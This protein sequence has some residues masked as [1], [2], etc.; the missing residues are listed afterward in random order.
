MNL[1][2]RAQL[3]GGFA[4]AIALLIAVFGVSFWGMNSMA[5]A[6]DEI[7][8]E[9]VPA[10]IAVRQ[11]EAL[12]LEQTITYA[13]YA[14]TLDPNDLT[15]VAHEIEEVE[16]AVVSLHELFGHDPEADRLIDVFEAEYAIFIHE[17]ARFI[18]AVQSA[19]GG[20]DSAPALHGAPE[21]PHSAKAENH[22]GGHGSAPGDDHGS[23]DSHG[24]TTNSEIVDLLHV[25]EAE[26][27]KMIAELEELAHFAE[28]KVEHAAEAASKAE[29][30]AILFSSII[31]VIA[32]V[33][34]AF[35]AYT[36]TRKI[37]NGLAQ[38]EAVATDMSEHTLPT[39]VRNM[40]L[41]A[42]GDLTTTF[43]TDLA[44][45][46][47]GQDDEIGKIKR[48]FNR[49]QGA[50]RNTGDSY[51]MM[52]REVSGLVGKV[53]E[54]SIDMTG[55]SGQLADASSQAGDATQ[56]LADASQQV[57]SGA[58]EQATNIQKSSQLVDELITS[59]GQVAEGSEKQTTEV[60][61]AQGVVSQVANASKQ[62][63]ENAQGATEGAQSA[64]KA[65]ENGVEVVQQ[66]IQGMNSIND[67]VQNVATEVANLGERSQEIGKIV[68]VIDDIAAQTNLLALNA[69]IE[70]A[71]AGEQGRGFA[72][73]ADEVRQLAERVSQATS[74]IAGLIESVQESVSTSVQATETGTK[75]V[76]EGT[77]LASGAGEALDEIIKAV[78]S[79][80]Q[81]VEEISGLAEEVSASSNEMVDAIDG[82]S[83]VAT[84]NSA[85]AAKMN[86][87]S[88]EVKGS[89]E[90]VS[91]VT[92]E[93]SAAAEETSASTE[94]MS[95]QVEEVVASAQ[96]LAEMAESLERSVEVFKISSDQQTRSADRAPTAE[97]AEPAGVEDEDA[98]ESQEAAA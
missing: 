96:T 46:D 16:A 32:A 58:Q 98:E 30:Q 51:N 25:L 42:S 50:V 55:A 93:T 61:R 91:A 33:A 38:V 63:A 26:E 13:D 1:T 19:A 69:A 56:G 78:G 35:L 14:I 83:S 86:D 54:M 3:I 80:T 11:L 6:T 60:N 34:L 85:V 52:M 43:D 4:L 18:E 94:E 39:L 74:E 36:L 40:E 90:A 27:E 66:T 72:V 10:D 70:A 65:A 64:N 71:R 77:T 75:Q 48:A 8:H 88:S 59:V 7:V 23:G 92:E 57:A 24:T 84:E 21:E 97:V 41:A 12:V 67:A 20:A 47:E 22:D 89:M 5:S 82:I 81:Q 95:A 79:V 9:D 76:E 68:S 44:D 62:V 53:R 31:G 37:T 49:I 87:A 29:S 28:A 17:G 15:K 2:I 73:V 45:I